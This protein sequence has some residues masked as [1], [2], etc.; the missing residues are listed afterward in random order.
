M[1]EIEKYFK[2]QKK[3]YFAA[4]IGNNHMG[5]LKSAF[6]LVDLA[7]EAQADAVKFQLITPELLVNNTIYP[8][9]VNQL[10]KICLKFEDLVKLRNH[11]SKIDIDFGISIFDLQGVKKTK[12]HLNPDFVKIAS[13]DF[14]FNILIEEILKNFDNVVISSGMANFDEINDFFN[15]FND[16]IKNLVFCYCVSLYPANIQNLNLN[17]IVHIRNL[18]DNLDQRFPD[19]NLNIKLGYSDHSDDKNVIISSFTLGCTFLE[20]HFTNDKYNK[21]FRDHNLSSTN[22]ELYQLIKDLK[23]VYE[24]LGKKDFYRADDEIAN[25]KELRRSA[26]Y[27]QDKNK[28]DLLTKEDIIFLRPQDNSQNFSHENYNN[29]Y[30]NKDVRK[31][32]IAKSEDIVNDKK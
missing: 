8:K 21:E 22:N 15:N 3:N 30:L 13:S 9:R 26:Y 18:L 20:K 2:D 24:S 28:G 11:C 25:I 29:S 12:E 16:Q 10:N 31:L 19:Q 32:D 6:E 17:N 1:S 27:Y 23:L 5:D 4:E 7:K 14:T